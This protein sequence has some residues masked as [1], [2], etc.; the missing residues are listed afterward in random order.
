MASEILQQP[1]FLSSWKLILAAAKLAQE[2]LQSAEATV[3]QV[4]FGFVV[5][6]LFTSLSP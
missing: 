4:N 6:L 2:S 5:G 3:A 1:E